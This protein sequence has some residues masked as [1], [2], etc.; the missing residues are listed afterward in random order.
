MD[1]EMVRIEVLTRQSGVLFGTSGVRGLEKDITDRVTYAFTAAFIR[2]LREEGELGT[3]GSIAIGGDLRPSTGRIARAVAKAIQDL[4]YT[5]DYCGL[6][7]SPALAYYGLVTRIPTVMVTGSHIPFDRNGIKYTK[8][9]GEILKED[10]GGILRQH[11]DLPS[12]LFDD[13]GAFTTDTGILTSGTE[14]RD[15]YVNRYLDFFPPRCLEGKRIGIYQHSAVGR[16]LVVSILSGL[17][18]D[19]TPL[20][21][22]DDFIPVDTEAIR[23]EDIDLARGWAERYHFDSIVSTD[24][25]SD[26]PLISDEKGTWLRGDVAGILC[27][28]YLGADTVVTPVSSNSAVE[29]CGFFR[30]VVRTKIGSPYVIEGMQ[31]ALET[32]AQIVLGYE[33]NGGVLLASDIVKSGKVLRALPTRDAMIL[34]ITVLLLSIEKRQCVSGLLA[35]LPRRYTSSDRLRDFPTERSRAR[36]ADLCCGDIERDRETLENVFGEYFGSVVSVDRTDG[37]RVTF[38]S[39]EVVHLRPSGNAPEFR[40]YNEADS[41]SRVMEMNRICMKIMEGW[42]SNDS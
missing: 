2:Y 23:P 30:R 40:C 35:G 39:G 3:R 25:D 36:I 29:K 20:G 27:A 15:L 38:E 14:A 1:T 22:S 7:P 41:E 37:I 21:Y 17:G 33:A 34:L 19:V 12:G 26:R 10:E 42:R 5:A 31:K 4:G 18:A 28:A 13:Q 32:G 6:I 9:D 8:R 11:V 24:G 16:D